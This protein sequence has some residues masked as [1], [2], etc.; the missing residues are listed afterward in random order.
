MA[1]GKMTTLVVVDALDSV[2]LL[3]VPE[4]ERGLGMHD[5]GLLDCI[6]SCL[7]WVCSK[8]IGKEHRFLTA[9]L[10]SILLLR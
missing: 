4:L 2:E 7:S 10:D 8:M 6:C 5:A 1:P 9:L 3:L